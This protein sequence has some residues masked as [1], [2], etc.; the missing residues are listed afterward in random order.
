MKSRTLVFCSLGFALAEA[1][2]FIPFSETPFLEFITGSLVFDFFAAILYAQTSKRDYFV[3]TFILASFFIL[4]SLGTNL[5]F[6]G[7]LFG[8]E[9]IIV[10]VGLSYL[11]D[12]FMPIVA[13]RLMK[14]HPTLNRVLCLPKS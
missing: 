4:P 5:P 8:A 11:Q 12:L 6:Y 10:I 7:G 2:W 3:S 14:H 9:S 13:F 1:M